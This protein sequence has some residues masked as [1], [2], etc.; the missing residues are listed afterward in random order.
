L[1]FIRAQKH[2]AWLIG[3]VIEGRGEVRIVSIW[4]AVATPKAFGGHRFGKQVEQSNAPRHPKAPSPLR[5]AG[6]VQDVN[7]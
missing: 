1:K 4:T 2:Q 6:A 5:S 3:N 7:A